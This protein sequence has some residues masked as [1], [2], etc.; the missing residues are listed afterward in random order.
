MAEETEPRSNRAIEFIEEL[1][2]HTKDPYAGVSFKLTPW[3]HKWM[4]DIFGT[5]NDDGTR[6]YRT[7]YVEIP[8]KN[9]KSEIAAAVALY[10]L[11]W[12]G[13]RGAEIYSAAGDKEQASIVFDVAAAM[14]RQQPLLNEKC[15]I[16][17]TYKRISVPSTNS[18]YQVL[19]AEHK[20][21]HG[22]NASGIIFDELH[23]QPNSN[24]F[25]VLTTSGG[26]RRQPLTFSI[27]TA[28]YDRESICWKMHEYA[29]KIKEGI[30]KDKT[31][32][33]VIYSAPDDA[34]WIDPKVW[35]ACNPALDDF[36]NRDELIALC[37]R[38]KE[39]PL[40]E[41]TFRRLYLNQWTQQETRFLPM[42]AWNACKHSFDPEELK[43]QR[44]FAGLDLASTT[45]TTALVLVFPD[46]DNYFVLPYFWIPD[47]SMEVRCRR[48]KVH[49]DTWV[50][51]GFMFTTPGN[52]TDYSFVEK[53]IE[54][55]AGIYQIE[56]INY[57]PWNATAIAQRLEEHGYNVAEFRQGYRDMSEPT[58]DLLRLVL[59]G[60]L[61]HNGHPVLRWQADN[62]V[63]TT[64]PAENLK[65]DKSKSSEKIDGI[66]A[67]I[68][69]LDAATRQ[70]GPSVYEGRGIK[71]I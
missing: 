45:D 52:A 68:M 42:H 59:A 17:D 32:Y 11:F 14:V 19:S 18:K 54:K 51:Q 43:G 50:Q 39:V 65:P 21:K 25:E 20:T 35:K 6:Q 2:C 5:F 64:D 66:V 53:Q 13:E 60:R 58:K 30:I 27:T 3:Q 7:V 36:R 24:L 47:E 49:Y 44:C 48:D 16:Y 22:F 57:D 9:G 33:P 67:L 61:R 29:R 69:A 40:F 26:T 55:L 12:D 10:L 34:E 8:R 62:V 46:G 41:N 31:F 15:K 23:A 38:A 56:Q 1:L 4:E 63:V 37:E 28:G 71:T 70:K